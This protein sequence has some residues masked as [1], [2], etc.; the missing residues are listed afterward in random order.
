[1][2]QNGDPVHMLES[3]EMGKRLQQALQE[4]PEK[5][6][7]AIVMFTIE[8]MPQ[9]QVAETL[10]VQRRGGEVARVPGPEEAEGAVEGPPVR[11]SAVCTARLR[12][13][14]RTGPNGCRDE[15][16]GRRVIEPS[17]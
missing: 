10:G 3:G 17:P 5:Q 4:L 7:L 11:R 8:Q 12:Q 16:T 6:R 2:A 13:P 1:M 15:G 9:K 14:G